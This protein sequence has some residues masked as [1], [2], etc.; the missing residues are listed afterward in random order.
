MSLLLLL[1]DDAFFSAIA[2]IGFALVFNVPARLLF[3]CAAGGAIG[4]S[5]R[6]LLM[7]FDGSIVWSSFFAA[8]LVGVIGVYWS[9]KY[10]VP[11]P[12]FTVASVIPMIPGTYAFKAMI[13]LLSMQQVGYTEVLMANL[14]ENGVTMVFIL[15]AL[16][17]GLALPS[18]VIYRFRPIV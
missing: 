5:F 14:F 1:L 3:L 10:L 12:V 4:H 15:L 16:S 17:F 9:R 8:A 18:V 13:S 7:Y 2:A 6:T 11:R